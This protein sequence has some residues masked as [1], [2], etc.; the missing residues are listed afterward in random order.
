MPDDMFCNDNGVRIKRDYCTGMNMASLLSLIF[1]C[2]R[3]ALL[4]L[5][6]AA[7][8]KGKWQMGWSALLPK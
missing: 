3:G 1:S 5:T 4:F 6:P 2:C 7:L 8:L